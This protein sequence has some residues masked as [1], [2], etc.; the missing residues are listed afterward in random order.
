M[1]RRQTACENFVPEDRRS[2][3]KAMPEWLAIAQ[4]YAERLKVRWTIV[5]DGLDRLETERNLLWLPTFVPE[6]IRLI[7][8]SRLGTLQGAL[9]RPKPN[10][11]GTVAF[12]PSAMGC[13]L[14]EKVLRQRL[15]GTRQII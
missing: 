7:V 6:S 4:A 14:T 9:K 11:F 3:L 13:L 8:S 2:L 1:V 12:S 5:L 15:R 10:F